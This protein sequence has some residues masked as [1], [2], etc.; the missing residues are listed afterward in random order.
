MRI[1]V[2][3]GVGEIEEGGGG[4]G[5]GV[6][7]VEFGEDLNHKIAYKIYAKRVVTI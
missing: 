3:K 7:D 5:E 4:G 1:V 2:G 6:V